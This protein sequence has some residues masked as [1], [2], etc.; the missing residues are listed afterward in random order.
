MK[1]RIGR[2]PIQQIKLF[3][4]FV[5]PFNM[6][7]SNLFIC[8]VST[9]VIGMLY[10]Y[11]FGLLVNEAFY[12]RN[13]DIFK[14]I[15]MWYAIVYISEQSLHFILNCTGAYLRTRF[16]FSIRL[17]LFNKIIY[18]KANSLNEKSTGD[19]ITIVNKDS[20]EVLNIIHWNIFYAFANVL[21]LIVAFI[22]VCTISI[23]LAVLMALSAPLA[24]YVSKHFAGKLKLLI[25]QQ[26]DTYGK[27]IGWIMEIVNGMREIRLLSAYK[28]TTRQYLGGLIRLIRIRNKTSFPQYYSDRVVSGI[29]LSLDLFLYMIAAIMVLK[30]TVSVGGVVAC[31]QYFTRSKELLKTLSNSYAKLMERTVA[32]NKVL[33]LLDETD[34]DQRKNKKELIVNDGM[35]KWSQIVF[36]YGDK[37]ILNKLDLTIFPGEKLAVVGASGAGK[38]TLISTLLDFHDLYMGHI[39]IDGQNIKEVSL[40]SL[41]RN[42]GIVHQEN[43][44]FQGTLRENLLIAYPKATEE[45]IWDAC[46]YALLTRVI[47]NLPLGL[48]TPIGI[49]GF[50]LSGGEVQRIAIARIFLRNPKIIIL[51][52][53]TSSLDNE[54]ERFIHES[55]KNLTDNRTSIIITH[56]LSSIL[57]CDRVAVLSEGKIISCDHHIKLLKNCDVYKQLFAEQYKEEAV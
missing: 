16:L 9:S 15:V 53:A 29:L 56:R 25:R 6:S 26:R 45:Q 40:K 10:P 7:F 39:E 47:Q 22:L 8:I 46:K 49:G 28:Y 4:H 1:K 5:K 50:N 57:N 23:P 19:L 30:G 34:E 32:L 44:V 3:S 27:F 55:W 48:E 37:E 20:E 31:I 13:W 36:N 17:K 2:F 24:A 52:E 54:S 35:I 41:R 12:H 42:I 11:I 51:D 21:R 18:S 33:N 43:V 38:S 14:T